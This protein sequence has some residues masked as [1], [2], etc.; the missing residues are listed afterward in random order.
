MTL[1]ELS[2]K[3]GRTLEKT[4][5]ELNPLTNE[6]LIKFGDKQGIKNLK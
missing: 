6:K 5:V 4:T 2:N 3:I 1:L